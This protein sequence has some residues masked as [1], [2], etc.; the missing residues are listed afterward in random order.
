[1]L[2]GLIIA[3]VFMWLVFS[4]H[5][6]NMYYIIEILCGLYCGSIGAITWVMIGDAIPDEAMSG[7]SAGGAFAQNLGF[8][9]GAAGFGSLLEAMGSYTAAMHYVIVPLYVIAIIVVLV[10]WKK[11]P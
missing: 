7:G 5:D 1:M 9:I 10:N 3:V 2:T 6:I 11:L 4:C 8:F